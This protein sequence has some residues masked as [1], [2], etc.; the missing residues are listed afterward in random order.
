MARTGTTEVRRLD[1]SPHPALRAAISSVAGVV[2]G[3]A[4]PQPSRLLT[5]RGSQH[6]LAAAS[7]CSMLTLSLLLLAE[8][9]STLASRAGGRFF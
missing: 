2:A 1:A 7:A 3:L 6:R 5:D 4:P 8:R 9:S